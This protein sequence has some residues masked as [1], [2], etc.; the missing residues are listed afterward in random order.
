[1]FTQA[2]SQ[3][4]PYT[5]E[6]WQ[7]INSLGQLVEKQLQRMG[8]GLTMGG[9]PTFVSLDDY[10]SPQWNI[11]A[12]GEDKRKIAVQLLDR[13]AKK[14]ALGGGLLHYGLGKAYPGEPG[15]RWALGYFWRKDGIAIW[16]DRNLMAQEGK[17][18]GCGSQEVEKFTL[19]LVKQLG[20][21]SDCLIPAY[22]LET[23]TPA[24]YVLPLLPVTRDEKVYWS[25]CRWILPDDRL[26]L[27][28][29]NSPMGLRL[30]LNAIAWSDNLEQEA[31]L[32][33]EAEPTALNDTPIKSPDNSIRVAMGVE[34]K[35]GVIRVFV[36]PYTSARSFLD[37][38]AAIENT[39]KETGF[40]VLI[41]G[42]PPSDHKAIGKFQIT[43]DPGVIEANIHP[44]SNWDEL[45]EITKILYEEARACRLGT[46]KYLRDGRRISTGGGAHITIGGKTTLESP[47]LRRP[48]LLRS[49]ISYFQNHPSLTYLFSDRFV[50]PTS[51]SPRVDEARHESLYELEIA[52][53][54]LQPGR[55]VPPEVV[56]RLLRHLL[57][58]VTGNTHRTA[59]CIDKL[60]PVEN[61]RTQLGLL[62]LR[63]IA[64]PPNLEMRLLQ[65]LLIRALVA[66]FWESPYTKPLI[67]WGTTLHDRFMLPHFIGEDLQ[68]VLF[69]LQKAG[70]T[71][72][73]DWFKPFIEFRF[74]CYGTMGTEGVQL[75]LRHAIEPWHVLGEE[76][77][78]GG[79]ARYVDDSLERIQ[80]KLCGAI[81]NSPNQN[82]F[83]SR[84]IVTCNGHA[85]PLNSTGVAGEYVGGV[86]YR[87]RQ[88]SSML[89][90]AIDPH[91]PLTFEIID[92]WESRS[93]GGCTY[94]IN[95]PD[96]KSYFKV[97][98]NSSEAQTRTSERF[99]VNLSRD[100]HLNKINVP[101]L[102]LN[103]EYPVTLDLRRTID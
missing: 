86:R 4:C 80:V 38:I 43:P 21:H 82:S 47:L 98:I 19:A 28:T 35:Q 74:P 49:L 27:L 37:A 60:F 68:V 29:G 58:D 12:L 79:T 17:D 71:F 89:H 2:R 93:L 40:P 32:P 84:Y 5:D 95:P 65:M 101:P 78:S 9:E 99:I 31:V 50:G 39:A 26:Y 73:F 94:L 70:Y 61:P 25:S 90:P 44:A 46:E 34:A 16:R 10:E 54:S 3:D 81:A 66:W 13:L 88:Y 7:N 63:A 14:F 57:V 45:V 22:E 76:I 41:E 85:V 64:M 48:D 6:Q 72:E 97:P 77:A 62:E 8:V 83:S 20:I 103:P 53:Q 23:D 18:Y 67:R 15:P 36:P 42:Y 87:A 11:E 102:Q 24:G 69:D 33:L 91:D 92:T 52:F 75:E 100:R 55:E 59:F 1:M 51:Q 56:D 30:P 96:G